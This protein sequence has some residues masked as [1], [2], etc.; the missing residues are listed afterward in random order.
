MKQL[1][2]ILFLVISN[3]AYAQITIMSQNIQQPKD[4]NFVYDS[5]QNISYGKYNGE[6][7]L[8]HLIGQTLM[9]CGD[10]YYNKASKFQVGNYYYVKEILPDDA[11]KGLYNR[12]SLIDTKTGEIKEE[13]GI[14]SIREYNY[15]WVVLG[16]Y[17]KIKN[18]Y[19]NKK[20]YLINKSTSYYKQ[21]NII[22]VATDTVTRGIEIGSEWTCIDIQVKPRTQNDW[23]MTDYRSPIILIFDNPKYGKHYCYL[24]D[25]LGEQYEDYKDWYGELVCGKF[26]SESYR[27]KIKDEHLRKENERKATLIKKYGNSIANLILQGKVRIGM[28]QE[29]CKEAWGQPNNINRTIGDFGAHEQWVYDGGQYL[30][31]EDGKLT[32][33][34][35]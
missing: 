31:F 16:Y 34:Q 23:M 28:T 10:P 11:S 6:N 32:A 30:Y 18:L 29:M 1:I 8:H 2:I 35:N 27:D 7:S 17:E 3:H 26:Q 25:C 20:F 21:D 33:I 14:S 22:N 12:L 4:K 5:L 13:G 19:L 9:Y 24:E 15:K